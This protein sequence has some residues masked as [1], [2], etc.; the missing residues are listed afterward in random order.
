MLDVLRAH[1]SRFVLAAPL[2]IA[3]FA[4]FGFFTIWGQGFF[5]ANNLTN[6]A[7]QS[8]A[9]CIVAVAVGIVM[10]AGYIDLSV[11][12]IIGISGVTAGYLMTQSH[13]HW[14]LASLAGV[15]LG[16]VAGLVNG[17]LVAVLRFSALIVT[18]GMLTILR[19][20]TFA[21]TDQ[22]FYDFGPQ[23]SQFGSGQYLG[24]PIPVWIAVA[25]CIAGGVF[26]KFTPTGRHVYAIGVNPE[27]AYF[28][29]IDIRRIPLLLFAVSGAAAGLAG[30]ITIARIDAAPSGSLGV[31]FELTALT[32][33]LLGGVS[34]SGGRGTIS[35]IILGVLFLGVLQNGLAIMNV[36]F[37]GQQIANGMALVVATALES[38]GAWISSRRR[39]S[40]ADGGSARSMR[41]KIASPMSAKAT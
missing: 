14:V 10:I 11:G 24:V 16:A 27:A 4:M 3:F 2:T 6:V 33:V 26:L 31:G 38:G 15:A 22:T 30:I 17:T 13:W 8:A 39:T 29:G 36:P 40:R 37:A 19:G 23:F 32:A 41:G 9:L 7:L 28:S 18:L 5:E 34:F 12:S 20:A 1:A 21:I 25:V 35:G